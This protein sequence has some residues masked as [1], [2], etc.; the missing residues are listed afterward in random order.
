MDSG[1]PSR[2]LHCRY[3]VDASHILQAVPTIGAFLSL[4]LVC[5]LNDHTHFKFFYRDCASCGPGSRSYLQRI[6]GKIA[7]NSVGAEE[8]GLRWLGAN[9]WRYWKR[10]GLDPPHATGVPGLRPGLR[11]LD[12]EN[13]A[14]WCHRYVADYTKNKWG[15]VAEIPHPVGP[16]TA[17]QSGEGTSGPKEDADG[18]EGASAPAWCEN[19][20]HMGGSSKV[21]WAGDYDELKERLPPTEEGEE[22][23]EVERIVG[24]KGHRTDKDGLFRVRWE[25]YPPEEDTWQRASELEGASEVCQSDHVEREMS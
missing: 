17:V 14:C 1:L 22:V 11:C 15:S 10:L 7:I 24:R 21:A 12:F 16:T 2:L 13:A 6:F 8:A 25:G 18:D 4:N 3:A 20:A 19:E 23:Y 5:Y 9:Q